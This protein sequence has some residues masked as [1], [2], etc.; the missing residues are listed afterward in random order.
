M[1]K[2]SK[3]DLGKIKESISDISPLKVAEGIAFG[4]LGAIMAI[5]ML[6]LLFAINPE[7]S[8]IVGETLRYTKPNN[9][10][11][12]PQQNTAVAWQN[13]DDDNGYNGVDTRP[14]NPGSSDTDETVVRD[15]D[16]ASTPDSDA[17]VSTVSNP[18]GEEDD[19]IVYKPLN[20]SDTDSNDGTSTPQQ[21]PQNNNAN[22]FN[23]P[24]NSVIPNNATVPDNFDVPDNIVGK[25]RYVDPD[26]DIITV[27]SEQEARQIE[28][29]VGY[30]ATGEGLDFDATYY[31][32][33]Q[34][35]NED[36]KAIYRQ[37]YANTMEYN[38]AFKPIR[39][40]N[41]SEIQTIVSSVTYDHPQLFW[42]DTTFYTE[43]DY[44]GSVIKLELSFYDQLGDFDAARSEFEADADQILAGATGLSSDYENEKYIH[45][46]LA[47]K[48][49]Y[50][51]NPLDQSA[52]SSIVRDYTVCAGY[53]KAFQYLMQ[54]LGVPTYLCVGWGA[55]ERHGWN[56]IRLDGEYY[57]VDV[58]W[59]DQDPTTYDYFNLSD[60]DNSMHTRTGNSV[61]LPPCNG[62]KYSGLEGS[63]SEDYGV[64]NGDAI[65][66]LADYYAACRDQTYANYNSSDGYAHFQLVISESLFNTWLED[67]Y[68]DGYEAGYLN[69]CEAAFGGVFS[70]PYC[71][72]QQLDDGTYLID[73]YVYIY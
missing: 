44:N 1:K 38:S 68:N 24:D 31:P 25:S 5:V 60:S 11:Q 41:I 73:H 34:F 3:P 61:Y 30:G 47:D 67:F 23:L 42:L 54:R 70:F 45:D 51:F 10:P 32:Y 9:T 35:L 65:S 64:A 71:Q 19:G 48:L 56:I 72:Y 8:N 20:V 2:L 14:L 49:Y 29:A 22:N 39:E 28:E 6:I 43:Y 12:Q 69:D 50:K 4:I 21:Q 52:Y 53:A 58:T 17:A 46:Y 36:Q 7:L 40:T 16:N 33:Y 26:P 15:P 59:D 57:N 55:T 18:S 13:N 37:V 63:S 66:S 27:D 62:S